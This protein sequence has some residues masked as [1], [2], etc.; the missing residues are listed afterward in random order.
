MEYNPLRRLLFLV[1]PTCMALV[2]CGGGGGA[3]DAP[4]TTV[5]AS[6]MSFSPT[7][8]K[9]SSGQNVALHWVYAVN[10]GQPVTANLLGVTIG[11]TVSTSDVKLDPTNLQR[12]ATMQGTVAGSANGTA[13][14]GAYSAAI[15]EDL[16]LSAGKTLFK[17]QSAEVNLTLSGGGESAAAKLTAKVGAFAPAYEWFL[18]RETL[19]Q[20][21]VGHVQTVTSAGAVDFNITLTGEAP[22]IKSNQPTTV[23]DRW[24]VLEKLPTMVVRG[25]SYAN[26]IKLS[27]QTRVPDFSGN[28]TNVTAYYWVAKGVGM[29]RGQGIFR[30]LNIDDVVYEL[31]DTNLSQQ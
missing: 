11:I 24:T 26:V 31:T 17:N 10:N 9:A 21:P 25:K 18:D 20:L 14:S 22:I 2:A 7:T 4:A 27:R 1:V 3:G 16:V 30:I 28:L 19:D 8:A 23:S 15:G 29:I 6:S 12:L 5:T 13:F